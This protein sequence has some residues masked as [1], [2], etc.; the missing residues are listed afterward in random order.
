[1]YVSLRGKG[2]F[3]CCFVCV[4][5][6]FFVSSWFVCLLSHSWVLED[7]N[8]WESYEVFWVSKAF[9]H[10]FF[11]LYCWLY[12]CCYCWLYP[13]PPHCPLHKNK[14]ILYILLIIVEW[15]LVRSA[16][17]SFKDLVTVT[18]QLHQPNCDVLVEIS[19]SRLW[20]CNSFSG[21]RTPPT[22]QQDWALIIVLLI[23][24]HALAW[25]C[26]HKTTY[27]LILTSCFIQGTE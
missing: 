10:D 26:H 18:W 2:S 24:T 19:Y 21:A 20:T 11:N 23:T 9:K 13:C 25:L 4:H 22:K 27:L 16:R 17:A 7:Y 14:H 12:T 3:C 5:N 6:L 15:S 8:R 1:M